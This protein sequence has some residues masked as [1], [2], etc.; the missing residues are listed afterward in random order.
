M[1]EIEKQEEFFC[2]VNSKDFEKLSC[3]EEVEDVE[4]K[5]TEEYKNQNLMLLKVILEKGTRKWEFVW[6]GIKIPAPV[7][8]DNFWE[9]MRKQE[10]QIAQGD[11]ITADIKVYQ[12]KDPYS[13]AF[14][15]TK[16][17]VIKIHDYKSSLKQK[18]D[19]FDNPK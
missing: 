6:N 11:S 3:N 5:R 4:T 12:T 9:K 7:L 17:E 2:N 19:L 16:Y 14:F 1:S 18:D 10:I 15:N 13:Q 8:D